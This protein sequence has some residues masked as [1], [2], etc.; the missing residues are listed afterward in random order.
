MKTLLIG[1]GGL[2]SIFVEWVNKA[3]EH[4]TIPDGVEFFAADDDIIEPKNIKYQNFKPED[5]G[6]NKAEALIN[7]YPY[8][9]FLKKRIDNKKDLNGYDY[10]IVAVDN[11]PTRQIVFDYCEGK[12]TEYLDLRAEGRESFIMTKVSHREANSTLGRSLANGSCQKP[13]GN[14][15]YGYLITA[16]LGFQVMMNALRGI[17]IVRKKTLIRS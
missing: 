7:R 5:V 1:L 14:I 10:I 4:G 2:G 13:K 9:E 17:P 16:A 8:I 3:Y 6:K 12:K 11:F 15:E